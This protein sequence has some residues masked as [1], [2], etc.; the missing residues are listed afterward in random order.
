M[1]QVMFVIHYITESLSPAI[2]CVNPK[3]C[4]NGSG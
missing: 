3:L 4:S 2:V 1:D